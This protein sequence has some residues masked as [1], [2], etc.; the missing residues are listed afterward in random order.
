MSAERWRGLAALVGDAV[1]HGSRA[2]ERVQIEIAR[3]PFALLEAI[4][5]V[6]EPARKAR[7]FHDAYVTGVHGALRRVNRLVVRAIDAAL[8]ATARPGG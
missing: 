8:D 1:E 5:P 4:P 2:V 7:T 6:A 3:R